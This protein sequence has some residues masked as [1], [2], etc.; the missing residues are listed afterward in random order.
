ME[1]IHLEQ[2]NAELAAE[3][4]EP[5]PPRYA[6]QVQSMLDVDGTP[7]TE[8]ARPVAAAHREGEELPGYE[9]RRSSPSRSGDRTEA[10]LDDSTVAAIVADPPPAY[11]PRPGGD[12]S[13]AAGVNRAVT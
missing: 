9:P 2:L 7:T 6:P 4:G 13:T 12:S 1:A 3:A 11:T 10:D 8:I 5:K